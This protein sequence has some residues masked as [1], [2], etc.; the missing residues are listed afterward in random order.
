MNRIQEG[1]WIGMESPAMR[2]AE[3]YT[4]RGQGARRRL[5]ERRSL[6]R[7]TLR[8]NRVVVAAVRHSPV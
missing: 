8:R 6:Q 5:T 4:A 7:T 2:R 3:Q 1:M